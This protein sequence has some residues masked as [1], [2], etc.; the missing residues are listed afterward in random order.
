LADIRIKVTA[1]P[2]SALTA[3]SGILSH[4][5]KKRINF[6]KYRVYAIVKID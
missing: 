3:D 6:V 2:R 5:V 1:Q 4:F